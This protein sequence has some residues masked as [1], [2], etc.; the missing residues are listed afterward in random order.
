MKPAFS[1]GIKSEISKLAKNGK[2][3]KNN[4]YST[5]WSGTRIHDRYF[6]FLTNQVSELFLFFSLLTNLSF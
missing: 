3:G 1:G 6:F 5:S 4:H 2:K